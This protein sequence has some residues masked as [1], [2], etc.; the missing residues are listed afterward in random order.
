MSLMISV[1]VATY[2]GEKY[3]REQ[4]VSIIAQLGPNDEVIV[5]DDGSVDCTLDI[6]SGIGDS[7]IRVLHHDKLVRFPHTFDYTTHNVENALYHAKGDFIFLADQDD[8]WLPGKVNV[9]SSALR[10]HLLVLSDCKVTD[11]SLRIMHESYFE[12]N[13]SRPGVLRNLIRNSFLGSCMAFR[14]ELFDSALPFPAHTVP[15]DIWLGLLACLRGK[16]AFVN[17]P[18]LFYRRHEATVSSSCRQ[19][20]FS[21]MF[22]V[23]YRLL[24]FWALL[25][26]HWGIS[27][28][29][30]PVS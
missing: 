28:F 15:H 7:R 5:S 22:K 26:R 20:S 21:L 25:K 6:I 18:L 11:A 12:L 9:M 2:N 14:R 4:L 17:Q 10:D 23:K 1:C 16:V 29:F 24:C 30:N 13:D 3:I 19:S 8:V 27:S